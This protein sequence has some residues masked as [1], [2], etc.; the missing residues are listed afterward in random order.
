MF[1]GIYLVNYVL[2]TLA[3]NA[4]YTSRGL[5]TFQDAMSLIEQVL[6]SLHDHML[7][8]IF[9]YG[10]RLIIQYHAGHSNLSAFKLCRSFGVQ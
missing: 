1:S 10:T 3:A 2:M 4:F 5:L 7:L 9:V 8:M 6:I